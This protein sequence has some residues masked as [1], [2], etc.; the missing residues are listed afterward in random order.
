MSKL[1]DIM[2]KICMILAGIGGV[3]FL[4]YFWP[5]IV[6]LIVVCIFFPAIFR[7]GLTGYKPHRWWD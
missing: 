2:I 6:I 7:S 1:E 5:L 3:V 4:Y